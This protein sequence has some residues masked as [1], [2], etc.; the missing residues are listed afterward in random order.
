MNPDDEN[1]NHA[2]FWSLATLGFPDHDLI[3]PRPSELHNALLPPDEQMLCF[4]YMYY[5]GA[6]KVQ[7][8][9]IYQ[10]VITHEASSVLALRVPVRL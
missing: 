6:Y 10:D 5:V 9:L 8:H 7:V 3:P 4:D 1:E 2:A